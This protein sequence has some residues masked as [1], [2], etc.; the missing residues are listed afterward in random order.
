M[1]PIGKFSCLLSKWQ[2]GVIVFWC[3][4][5]NIGRDAHERERKRKKI[6]ARFTTTA[7]EVER[8]QCGWVLSIYIWSAPYLNIFTYC[9]LDLIMTCERRH[10]LFAPVNTFNFTT[11]DRLRRYSTPDRQDL[12]TIYEVN[13]KRKSLLTRQRF[14]QSDRCSL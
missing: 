6:E 12:E 2:R 5:K 13:R 10:T 7:L 1:T 8:S 4:E 9:L 3:E 14:N 11:N